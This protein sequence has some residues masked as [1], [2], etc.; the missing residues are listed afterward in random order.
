MADADAGL[1][2]AQYILGL[3]YQ[4]G[5]IGFFLRDKRTYQNFE[6]AAHQGHRKAQ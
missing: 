3:M 5:E 1:A 4:N 6:K 2:K